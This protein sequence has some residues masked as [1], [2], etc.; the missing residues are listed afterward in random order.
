LDFSKEATKVLI[1]QEGSVSTLSK[2][3]HGAAVHPVKV[4]TRLPVAVGFRVTF[5]NSLFL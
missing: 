2:V 5:S 4:V 3:F 1:A